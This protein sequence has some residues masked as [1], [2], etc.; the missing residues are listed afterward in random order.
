MKFIHA[1]DIHLDSAQAG[2][3][4]KA[5]APREK[6]RNSTRRALAN[7][8]DLA[9]AEAVDFVLIAG[10]L[11]DGNWRDYNTGLHF[12][13]EMARLGRIP[14]F[15]VY[16]NHDAQNVLTKR[17]PLPP[18]VVA[19]PSSKPR[20]EI[21]RELGLAVHGQSFADR[22]VVEN[23]AAAYPPP[24]EGLF[25]IGLLHTAA[26][27]REG[28]LPYAPCSVAELVAKD[29]DY[30]ALGHVH[31]REVLWEH[32]HVVF[33]GNLQGRH[34]R[35]T[36]AKGCTLV[37]VEDGR[38]VV[39]EHR[40][41]DVLRW[42]A[43][44]VD[45]AGAHDIAAAAERVRDAIARACDDADGRHLAVRLTL[46]G[47]CEAHGAMLADPD[48]LAAECR[49]AALAVSDLAWIEKAVLR[50]RPADA[51]PDGIEGRPDALGALVR[52]LDDVFRDPET[53]RALSDALQEILAKLPEE[54]KSGDDLAALLDPNRLGELVDEARALLA[55][56]LAEGARGA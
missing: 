31:E 50:T 37:R 19:F 1:A 49:A 29:Y 54:A 12:A 39:A 38:I 9:L 33:P 18:N 53:V 25:N 24:V 35:E 14:V 40:P 5:G 7:M 10:D 4:A 52:S 45:V 3:S 27:G 30:W 11:Y 47:A 44:E 43:L 56:R 46:T 32:P 26:D 55:V 16:G 22:A 17:L 23:L 15:L 51:G 34:A 36:G 21:V 6:L 41:V 13:A 2:V 20:T 48:L 8:V 28:H 42:A